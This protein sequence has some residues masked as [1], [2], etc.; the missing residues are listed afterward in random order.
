MVENAR[1]SPC[2]DRGNPRALHNHVSTTQRKMETT[3][4]PVLFRMDRDG[5]VFALFPTIAA[6]HSGHCS[7]YQHIGQHSAAD[8]L[9]C[10]RES[11]PAAPAQ[12]AA[13]LQELSAIGYCLRVVFR[14]SP[15]MR[16][17]C[18]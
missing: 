16:R 1:V 17:Q 13:L 7:C 4:T 10:I 2:N 12:Y 11:K 14:Q 15:A 3:T 9:G 8:Y 6:D 18:Q 5:E